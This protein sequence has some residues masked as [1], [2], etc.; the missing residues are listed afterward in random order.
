MA[1][2]TTIVT[3]PLFRRVYNERLRRDDESAR[4]T[5]VAMPAVA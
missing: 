4:S 3:T 1:V 5:E 2:V